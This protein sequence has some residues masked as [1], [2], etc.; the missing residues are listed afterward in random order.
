MM[1]LKRNSRFFSILIFLLGLILAIVYLRAPISREFIIDIGR[2]GLFGAML[3]GALYSFAFTSSIATVIFST[4]PY[5]V[6]PLIVAFFG[7][8]GAAMYDLII[9]TFVRAKTDGSF[10]EALKIKMHKRQK[11]ASVFLSFVGVV[12]LASPLPD[13]LAAGILGFSKLSVKNFVFISFLANVTGIFI[14]LL[15]SN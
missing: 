2:S 15:I 9:F 6:H 12:I 11:F 4:A 5:N 7:G 13:E 10:F 14:I 8:L 1:S 3:V